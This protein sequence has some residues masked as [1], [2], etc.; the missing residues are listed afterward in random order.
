ML[1]GSFL[2]LSRHLSTDLLA[3]GEPFNPTLS[4]ATKARLPPLA[5]G[6]GLVLEPLR[7]P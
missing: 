2:G 3:L 7:V 6:Y 5:A 4:S 1:D